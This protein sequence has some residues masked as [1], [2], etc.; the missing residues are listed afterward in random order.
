MGRQTAAGG[1]GGG[2]GG[3]SDGDG[4]AHER[5]NCCLCNQ[6]VD[7]ALENWIEAHCS[8]CGPSPFHFACVQQR[9]AENISTHSSNTTVRD[10]AKAILRMRPQDLFATNSQ[11]QKK[12]QPCPQPA[13]T[14]FLIQAD[15]HRPPPAVLRVTPDP[16]H[17]H[18]FELCPD[19]AQRGRCF[20]FKCYFAHSEE[21]LE[22]RQTE[23]AEKAEKAAQRREARRLAKERRKAQEEEVAAAEQEARAP[24]E[25]PWEQGA[26]A[27]EGRAPGAAEA[28]GEGSPGQGMSRA[29]TSEASGWSSSFEAFSAPNTSTPN[30]SASAPSPPGVASGGGWE[31]L[32][33][34]ARI[35][36]QQA[37]S[38]GA[39][40]AAAPPPPTP[41]AAELAAQAP[42]GYNT[43]YAAGLA[44]AAAQLSLPVEALMA[45]APAPAQAVLH[46]E[47]AWGMPPVLA[48]PPMPAVPVPVSAVPP[49]EPAWGVVPAADPWGGAQGWEGA[50]QQVLNIVGEEEDLTE[51]L[52]ALGVQV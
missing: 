43:G 27:A 28:P 31:A 14:G 24:E 12:K 29:S 46:P 38:S 41:P 18:F 25:S 11:V 37:L 17:P 52:R 20:E 40:S 6:S 44:A 1:S 9:V 32:E 3:P 26:T 50:Q 5:T 36:L 30:A 7:K 19:Q 48:P 15:A 39:G 23:A 33:R 2:S 47:P 34:A 51:L 35:S 10:K 13:C 16:S 42:D 22:A 49:P 21:E 8:L 4:G 45:P